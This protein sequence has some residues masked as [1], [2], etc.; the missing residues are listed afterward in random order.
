MTQWFD[1]LSAN[2]IQEVIQLLAFLAT[3]I[4]GIWL[5]ILVYRSLTGWKSWARWRGRSAVADT[6]YRP[7]VLW[8]LLLGAFILFFWRIIT[9]IGEIKVR[10]R[11]I[12]SAGIFAFLMFLT[13][14]YI[15]MNIGLVPATGIPLPFISYGGSNLLFNSLAVGVILKYLNE[16]GF[17]K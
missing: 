12:A 3:C 2:W 1:W 15:G 11:K 9:D 6:I 7:C 8:F 17:M 14:I 5:R 10:E 16:R 4:V 13:F